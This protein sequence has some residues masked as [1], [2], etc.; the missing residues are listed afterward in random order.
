MKKY[1]KIPLNCMKQ[2][3]FTYIITSRGCPFNCSFCASRKILW[4]N[5]RW[6]SP[7]RVLHELELLHDEGFREVQFFDDNFTAKKDR[8]KKILRGMIERKWDFSWATPNGISIK[9]LDEEM[10]DLMKESGCF[11]LILAIESG[12][13]YVLNNLAKKPIDLKKVPP[14]VRYL[15]KI[16]IEVEVLFMIGFPGETRAQIMDTVDF[17]RSLDADYVCFYIV[18]PLPGTEIWD[19]AKKKGFLISEDINQFNYCKGNIKTPEFNPEFLEKIR[20]EAWKEI[21]FGS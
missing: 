17:A 2:E 18:T 3:P 6:H 12:N 1:S 21:N 8:T 11:K 15:K 20:F 19:V 10:M 14:I 13:Q 9:G 16:G 7:E 5:Y 4:G